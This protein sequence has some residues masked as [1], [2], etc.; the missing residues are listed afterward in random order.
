[1]SNILLN[2]NSKKIILN[3]TQYLGSADSPALV[4]KTITQNGTYLATN[5]NADGYSEVNINVPTTPLDTINITDNGTY[6]PQSGRGFGEVNVNVAGGLSFER[7]CW[8]TY[9]GHDAEEHPTMDTLVEDTNYNN[10]LSYDTTTG[11]FTVLADF[12]ALFVPYVYQYSTPSGSYAEGEFY[13]NINPEDATHW[14]EYDAY[15]VPWRAYGATAGCPIVKNAEAGDFFL[16][17]TPSSKGF[18]QQMLK[19]YKINGSAADV[20]AL[21]SILEFTAPVSQ[22]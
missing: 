2:G 7:L 16:V 3:G 5:D 8:A 15:V 1:M 13:Y 9:V 14:Y 20:S 6:H 22:E 10:Y 17:Y 11:K 21:Q 18:P 4:T 19:V 12:N